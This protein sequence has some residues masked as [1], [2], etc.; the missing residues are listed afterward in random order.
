MSSSATDHSVFFSGG[1]PADDVETVF[2]TLADAV[3]SRA[4]AYPDGEI[5][6]RRYWIASIPKPVYDRCEQLEPSKSPYPEGSQL[7]E[8]FPSYRIKPGVDEVRLEGLLH[9]APAAIESY[10]V[11][12]RLRAEGVIE[13]NV[14]FQVTTPAAFDAVALFF[15]DVEE[16]PTM[17]RAWTTALQEEH[18]R[19][20]EVIPPEDLVIQLDYC[21]ELGI[22]HGMI[23][24]IVPSVTPGMTGEV[25]L[26]YYTSEEYLAPHWAAVP[27]SAL[28][29][30]HVCLGTFPQRPM[31]PF[32][33]ISVP[34][35]IAN[36]LAVNSGRRVDYFH[37][38]TLE[39]SGDEYFAPLANLDVGESRV[40][41]GLECND[42]LGQMKRRMSA[43]S[44]Y[45]ENFGVAHYCGYMWNQEVLPQLLSDLRD[46]ADTRSAAGS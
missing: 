34:V 6:E 23:A 42:G 29:G 1:V 3:G 15:P 4:L 14:R 22:I 31:V 36:R 37:L 17:F 40:Y 20:L 46:G 24:E 25:A 45:L 39:D 21:V 2:R 18:R 11:F 35:E 10:E 43:A 9:Y 19:I 7:E 13:P 12:A 5:N 38:P 44:R 32:G 33:D 28:A 26:D 30:Y 8:T 27:D 16:W 41:L